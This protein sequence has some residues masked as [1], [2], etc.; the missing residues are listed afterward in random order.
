MLILLWGLG[1]ESPLRLVHEELQRLKARTRLV[2]QREVLATEVTLSVGSEIFGSVVTP[3]QN[4]DLGEVTAAYI[5]PYDSR[6]L[7]VVSQAGSD[8]YEWNHAL[9]I[10]DTL[11]S[12]AEVTPSLVVN[13]LGNMAVNSSKP[14]QLELIRMLGFNTPETLVTTVPIEAQA[15]WER[16]GVVIYK[17]VSGL[18]SI[19][20]R[21][22]PEHIERLADITFCP[23]QF[24]QY[25]TGCDYRVHV[26][27][28]EIFAC[29]VSTDATDYRY[30]NGNSVEIRSCHLPRE[31]E[32]RCQL[33]AAAMSL[34]VAGID[35]RR[36][37][38]GEW[39]CFEVNPSPAFSYY[40]SESGQPISSAI[41]RLL[42]NGS[43]CEPT[44]PDFLYNYPEEGARTNAF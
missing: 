18:R 37:P 32:D 17:S 23:T 41:A 21:L 26:V 42:I 27:G 24:Q 6:L 35:L 36:S 2:D 5:R 11:T 14:Y 8:S 39:Y 43:A 38:D 28:S 15:F 3:D 1:T 44:V 30:P 20:S 31:E 25:I 10:D 12:W 22:K 16:H 34:P 33:L 9:M 7:P 19:V 29:E 40:Q 4:I 13:R